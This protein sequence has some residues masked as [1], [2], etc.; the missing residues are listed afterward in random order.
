MKKQT[1]LVVIPARGGS[2]GV[3]NKNI[4]EINGKPLIE[5]TILQAKKTKCVEY[6]HV[7]TDSE[8]IAE[9][10]IRAGANCDFLRPADISGDRV[11]TAP[12]IIHSIKELYKKKIQFDNVIELQPTYCLRGSSIISKCINILSSDHVQ[13][14]ITCKKID[15]TEHPDY[16]IKASDNGMAIFGKRTPGEFRRQDLEPVYACH[17]LVIAAKVNSFLSRESFFSDDCKLVIVDDNNRF[18]DINTYQDLEFMRVFVKKYPE[19]LL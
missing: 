14:V 2:K 17:G 12:T 1:N 9:I 16:T 6:I 10:S 5:W 19:Y 4:M 15:T 13:S 3:K 7:S 11:G 18:L 8:K